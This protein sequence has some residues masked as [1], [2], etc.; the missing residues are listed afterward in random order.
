M[1]DA[2]RIQEELVAQAGW[3][4]A[5][6]GSM[7]RDAAEADDVAQEA[8]VAALRRGAP[9]GASFRP[10]I[11]HVVRNLL[12]Q[13]GRG[14][15]NRQHREA[16]AAT[17]E[18]APGTSDLAQ[19]AELNRRLVDL[20]LQLPEAQRSAVLLH[21]FS[22]VSI[23]AIAAARGIPS[24]TTRS[25]LFRAR[26]TLRD[27]LAADAGEDA[28]EGFAS[29]GALLILASAPDG[30]AAAWLHP[31]Y[32]WLMMNTVKV[33]MVASVALLASLIGGVYL[34]SRPEE[35][36]T[37][38]S[39]GETSE[40]PPLS[41]ETPTIPSPGKARVAMTDA[42]PEPGV[43]A[44]QKPDP[45]PANT[46]PSTPS[47]SELWAE[48]D[49]TALETFDGR[50]QARDGY[51]LAMSLLARVEKDSGS[52]DD[53]GRRLYT[54]VDDPTFGQARLRVSPSNPEDPAYF[55]IEIETGSTLSYGGAMD[56][57]RG[58]KL[59]MSLG[60]DEG[61]LTSYGANATVDFAPSHNPRVTNL[62]RNDLRLGGHLRAT[63][64]GAT[65]RTLTLST[66]ESSDGTP[67]GQAVY[68]A[69]TPT[70]AGDFLA[71]P[72]GELGR[73]LESLRVE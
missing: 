59:V 43:E 55:A 15:R 70:D 22:G 44:A 49:A 53:A 16:L 73:L 2:D 72:A 68:S 10:W 50:G 67:E 71:E 48:V 51:R 6:A 42:A 20:V 7:L 17:P 25:H 60:V 52:W 37:P 9:T 61:R 35:P 46:T 23:E 24:A 11:V 19:R 56:G 4:R 14:N 40:R 39:N 54:L 32:G 36:R 34:Y 8:C 28:K 62:G 27:Q 31:L 26:R 3:I 12:R 30:R 29:L 21:Y 64:E 5:L 38:V 33:G 58:A 66:V 47:I 18:D 65:W 41:V 13:V 69:S 63:P 57:V 45:A 1:Q